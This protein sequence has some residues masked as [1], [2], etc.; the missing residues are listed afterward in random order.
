M[1]CKDDEPKDTEIPDGVMPPKLTHGNELELSRHSVVGICSPKTLKFL[2]K[3]DNFSVVVLVDSDA[4]HSFISQQVVNQLQLPVSPAKFQVII[5][6][7]NTIEGG[8]KCQGVMLQ[9][10]EMQFLQ[11][12]YVFPLGN[13]DVI[14]GVDRLATLGV[15]KSN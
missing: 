8:E 10:L 6:N 7:G 11:D 1:L 5:G 13:V 12:Y 4:S 3:I 2:G 14:L 15:I 9:L